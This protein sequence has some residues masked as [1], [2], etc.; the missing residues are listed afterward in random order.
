[1]LLHDSITT[2]LPV[3]GRGRGRKV[4]YVHVMKATKCSIVNKKVTQQK[5]SI[6]N[7]LKRSEWA[8]KNVNIINE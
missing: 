7:G 2:R 8:A 1:M 5:K 6:E 4:R 3:V